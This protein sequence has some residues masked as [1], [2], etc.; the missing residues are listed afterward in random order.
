[1]HIIKKE[2]I[3]DSD[4]LTMLCK[5]MTSLDFPWFLLPNTGVYEQP[6]SVYD[7]V[8]KKF[9]FAHTLVNNGDINSNE[10]WKFDK[11]LHTLYKVFDIKHEVS[12][13]F[14][15]RIGHIT[16]VG[17]NSVEHAPHIDLVEPHRTLLFYFNDSSG[18]TRFYSKDKTDN[19]I[20]LEVTPKAN[21][22]YDFDGLIYHSSSTPTTNNHR[23]VLNIN[24]ATK[25]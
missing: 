18:V 3:I 14:R 9:S 2:N 10:I 11:L 16:Y 7:R 12:Y 25:S 8:D 23:F 24:Y 22:A 15:I 1:M 13:I 21:T 4:H 5:H 17:D 6:D 20:S 19:K